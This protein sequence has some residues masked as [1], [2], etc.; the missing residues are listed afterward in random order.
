MKRRHFRIFYFCFLGVAIA[1]GALAALY[2]FFQLK[3]FE[4]SQPEYLLKAAVGQMQRA[5][6][7][8]T[9]DTLLTVPQDLQ[10][11]FSK[12]GVI[13]E[14]YKTLLQ[15]DD[16]RFAHKAGTTTE[17]GTDY[18]IC[19]GTD[20][21][22]TVHLRVKN[23]HTALWFLTITEYEITTVTPVYTAYRLTLPQQL[24]VTVNGEK[25]TGTETADGILYNVVFLSHPEVKISDAYGNSVVY[26]DG[27]ELSVADYTI[28]VPEN[29]KVQVGQTTLDPKQGT[30]AENPEYK[31]VGDYCPDLPQNCTYTVTLLVKNASVTVTDNLGKSYTP[32]FK[33]GVYTCTTQSGAD[34]VPAEIK[35]KIDPLAVAQT[36]AK[37]LTQDLGTKAQSYGY[38]TLKKYLINDSYLDDKYWKWATNIDVAFTSIHTLCNPPF[39]EEKVSN[40]VQ[41]SDT[42]FSCDVSFYYHFKTSISEVKDFHNDTY[43]FVYTVDSSKSSKPAWFLVECVSRTDG[44]DTAD[45]Q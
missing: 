6:A 45:G 39:L 16:L 23:Q 1:L 37:Y 35:A 8:D 3:S 34:T 29:F 24:T 11:G 2:V 12:G 33:N 28:T 21:L 14:E 22:A 40:F 44:A 42:C 38:F 25:L 9:L 32:E 4:R 10:G 17:D 26:E 41:Y 7:D 5:C 30:L 19:S 31:Y 43:Y 18:V 20:P 36:V 27:T 15:S 13:Y